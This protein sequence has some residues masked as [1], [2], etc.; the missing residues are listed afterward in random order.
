MPGTPATVWDTDGTTI[1]LGTG[2]ENDIASLTYQFTPDVDKVAVVFV[3]GS[4][5]YNEFVLSGFND[6]F[7]IRLTGPNP[8]GG[9]YNNE[10]LAVVPG[11]STGI[12]IDTINNSVNPAFYPRQYCG[13]AACT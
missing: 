10:N 1:D 7:E 8:I 2:A 12:S 5:E 13:F 4:D 11:T 9:S 3:F 6:N